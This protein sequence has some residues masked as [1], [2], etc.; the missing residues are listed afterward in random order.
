[1]EKAADAYSSLG[2]FHR[3]E[4][5][6]AI[7]AYIQGKYGDAEGCAKTANTLVRQGYTHLC[8]ETISFLLRAVYCLLNCGYRGEALEILEKVKDMA[9]LEGQKSFFLYLMSMVYKDRDADL[10]KKY[11]I[12]SLYGIDCQDAPL[13]KTDLLRALGRI[14]KEEGNYSE[15]FRYLSEGIRFMK[16]D[17]EP[18]LWSLKM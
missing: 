3:A 2:M 11:L 6:S 14:Y 7:G 12:E 10:S 15:A 17:E 16:A 4:L 5:V 13:F 18:A 9:N 8:S 1:L